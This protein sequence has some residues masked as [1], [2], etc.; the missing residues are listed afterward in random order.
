MQ[1]ERSSDAL[2]IANLL[3]LLASDPTLCRRY[4]SEMDE[5]LT[6]RLMEVEVR[7]AMGLI[8]EEA[9]RSVRDRSKLKVLTERT[10]EGIYRKCPEFP[11]KSY[12]N[13][14]RYKRIGR[15]AAAWLIPLAIAGSIA[16]KLWTPDRVSCSE[17]STQPPMT[18]V[19]S[20][21]A[22]GSAMISMECTEGE[23]PVLLPDGT[24]VQLSEGA[25]LQYA[26]DF[27]ATRRVELTGNAFFS[28]TRQEGKTFEVWYN[29][30][31]VKVVGTE[32]YL[33]QDEYKAEVTLC[34]GVVE[35]SSG[36]RQVVLAPKQQLAMNFGTPDFSVIE[37]TETQMARL[38]RGKLV[39]QGKPLGV[40]L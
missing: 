3:R 13:L 1:N 30:M 32:F 11:T 18:D 36:D 4:F 10:L 24:H 9:D 37:L 8:W 38:I 23:R 39:I 28:V 26:E 35:V 22:V 17:W 6:N 15:K 14:P 27:E 25:R 34:S 20:A 40:A 19:S 2:R 31:I 7:Q 12:R 5:L 21:G 29:D 33:H 16:G